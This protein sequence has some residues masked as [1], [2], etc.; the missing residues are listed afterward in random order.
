VS[1]ID[2]RMVLGFWDE[3]YFSVAKV[4]GHIALFQNIFE[5]LK[6]CGCRERCNV[7]EE[8]CWEYVPLRGFLLGSETMVCWTLFSVNN[9]VSCGSSPS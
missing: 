4:S 5:S 8:F 2:A 3:Y 7:L 6:E 9:L 1:I